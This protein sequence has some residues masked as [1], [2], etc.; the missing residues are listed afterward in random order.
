[1]L[2]I[3]PSSLILSTLSVRRPGRSNSF[4][5]PCPRAAFSL[6]STQARL[7]EQNG[8]TSCM[9]G[10]QAI[11]EQPYAGA[12]TSPFHQQTAVRAAVAPHSPYSLIQGIPSATPGGRHCIHSMP[13]LADGQ[14]RIPRNEWP[15]FRHTTDPNDQPPRAIYTVHDQGQGP[16]WLREASLQ[17]GI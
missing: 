2:A 6:L 16:I 17:S 14:V 12:A 7:V 8:R 4:P 11:E 10:E 9:K 5:T 13:R 3:L 1:M 15:I